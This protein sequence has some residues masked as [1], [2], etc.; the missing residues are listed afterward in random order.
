M[1]GLN[2]GRCAALRHPA[3]SSL[4]RR[5]PRRLAAAS[6]R[7]AAPAASLPAML[8]PFA[9]MGLGIFLTQCLNALQRGLLPFLVTSGLTLVRVKPQA[10]WSVFKRWFGKRKVAD[11]H[12]W[13]RLVHPATTG[14]LSACPTCCRR[15]GTGPTRFGAKN[16][17]LPIK[18]WVTRRGTNRRRHVESQAFIGLIRPPSLPVPAPSWRVASAVFAGRSAGCSASPGSIYRAL[19]PWRSRRPSSR[20]NE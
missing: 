12:G 17:P 4:S 10:T 8:A 1:Q 13:P 18:G 11:E 14:Y 19:W 6:G 15:A 5:A 2:V 16:R 3:N 7:Q 20:E 9:A